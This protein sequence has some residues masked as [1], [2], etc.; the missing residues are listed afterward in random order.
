MQS[1]PVKLSPLVWAPTPSAV[2]EAWLPRRRLLAS[3]PIR[4]LPRSTP[5]S[6]LSSTPSVD[7]P[8]VIARLQVL[9]AIEE[10]DAEEQRLCEIKAATQPLV[11]QLGELFCRRHTQPIQ[12]MREVGAPRT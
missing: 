6:T 1:R 2:R 4:H 7:D 12:V 3:T 8:R 9:L 11:V 5:S 10:A